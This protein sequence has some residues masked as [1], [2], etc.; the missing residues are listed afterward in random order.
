MQKTVPGKSAPQ[1]DDFH[2]KLFSIVIPI[3]L[4]QLMNSFVSA[5]DALMLGKLD[6]NSLSSVSL[7]GQISFV[8]NLFLATMTIGLSTLAAQY[9]GKKDR[10]AVERIFAYVMKITVCIAMLFFLAGMCIP[11]LLMRL[12][13]PDA[14]L[15]QGGALYLRS[16]SPSYLFTAVTQ[17]YLCVLKNSG[18]AAKVSLISS[19]CLLLDVVLNALF[20]FGLFGLPRMGILGA[21]VSTVATR[22]IEMVW[23]IAESTHADRV[24][25]RAKNL[26]HDD[27]T[28]RRDFWKY[29]LPVLG[30][31]IVW[32]VG[33]T[34]YSVIMGHMGSDAVAAN[35]IA[36]VA[37]NLSVCF[38]MGLASGSGI[39][40][41]HELGAGRLERAK[42][43]GARLCRMSIISGI[44]SGVVL[45][46]VSPLI[47]CLTNMTEQAYHYL[48][49]MLLMCTYNLVGKSFNCTTIAG[50]FCAGGDTKFGFKCDSI[51][52]WGIC[53]P[54]GLL[55]AF[56]WKLPVLIVYFL[57]NLDEMFKM[58]ASFLHYRKYQWVKDLTVQ[59]KA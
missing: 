43:Y 17:V 37:K 26:L 25:L 57:I 1:K 22:A 39:L 49:G 55:A 24:K 9:W 12:Y 28:L 41:G 54:L 8:E 58:P 3:A 45:L 31:E 52:M 35:S 18:R 10:D 5:S 53:V 4:Q 51:V 23:A 16:V 15:I 56:V 33:F 13:T 27:R 20:I 30:N 38:C 50:I 29:A 19:V 7:A 14:A 42:E 59:K 2:K 44:L 21:S 40:V 6:Q 48:Q 36:S 11:E 34:M 46:A 47:F 32:G